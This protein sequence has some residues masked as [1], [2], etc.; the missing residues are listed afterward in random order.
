MFQIEKGTNGVSGPELTESGIELMFRRS[1]WVSPCVHFIWIFL[2][3]SFFSPS[4]LTRIINNNNTCTYITFEQDSNQIYPDYIESNKET[5]CKAKRERNLV[6]I[7][8]SFMWFV[9]FVWVYLEKLSIK[10]LTILTL[11]HCT[12]RN[13][14]TKRKIEDTRRERRSRRKNHENKT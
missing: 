9:W 12:K 7:K 10:Y 2:F 6:T 3:F 1:I 5:E 8:H 4:K 11:N 13:T 14:R